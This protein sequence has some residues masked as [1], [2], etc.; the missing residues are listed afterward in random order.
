MGII[1]FVPFS[2]TAK[3]NNS[4]I[5]SSNQTAKKS[6]SSHLAGKHRKIRPK[7]LTANLVKPKKKTWPA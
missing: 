5:L 4:Y 6:I 3:D 1:K 7:K 2:T